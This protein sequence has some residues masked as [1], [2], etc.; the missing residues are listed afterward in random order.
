MKYNTLDKCTVH[1]HQQYAVAYELC[2][3]IPSSSISQSIL[4]RW[5]FSIRSHRSGHKVQ[6]D[7]N[8]KASKANIVNMRSD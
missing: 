5:Y 4:M 6:Y 7:T 3:I 2:V 8:T 1:A